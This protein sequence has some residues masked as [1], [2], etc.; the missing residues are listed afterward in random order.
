MV[1][2]LPSGSRCDVWRLFDRL[3]GRAR[4]E[5][6]KPRPWGEQ[7]AGYCPFH[8]PFESHRRS[9]C[10]VVSVLRRPRWPPSNAATSS[11]SRSCFHPSP[12]PAP[13]ARPSGPY[14]SQPEQ[15]AVLSSE[16]VNND[17]GARKES[18]RS[19]CS[20]EGSIRL[21]RIVATVRPGE[22]DT[23]SQPERSSGSRRLSHPRTR[24]RTGGRPK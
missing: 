1:G 19:A 13:A 14:L 2:P 5:T 16:T 9:L 4:P 6:A 7:P 10:V 24:V 8:S 18:R 15:L 11:C 20:E 3:A 12:C 23:R 21:W 17:G 22:H